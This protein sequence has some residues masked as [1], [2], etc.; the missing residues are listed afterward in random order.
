MSIT[1]HMSTGFSSYS[2]PTYDDIQKACEHIIKFIHHSNDDIHQ[3][4]AVVG[5][6]RGG[7]LP[8]VIMSHHLALPMHT[9]HYSSK[10]GAGD[11]HHENELPI[12]PQKNI[13]LVDDLTDS[14]YT[15]K[16]LHEI[17]T[18]R[19]H[20]VFT[21]VIYFKESK[22]PVHV[23]DVWAVKLSRNF[24]WIYFPFEPKN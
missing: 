8:A 15:M 7:L 21:A 13:L 12:I 22:E 19:G 20:N 18:E 10:K 1:T 16:E 6:A 2:H 24:G 14:G 23:P 9:V 11:K 5:I 4:E 3:A 17:Y